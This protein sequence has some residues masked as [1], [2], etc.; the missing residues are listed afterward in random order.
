[1]KNKNGQL[2]CD[3][4]EEYEPKIKLQTEQDYIDNGVEFDED[5]PPENQYRK[6]EF[7]LK[8]YKRESAFCCP[9]HAPLEKVERSSKLMSFLLFLNMII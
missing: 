6:L 9:K 3:L 2:P 1:M 4:L 5:M 7:Y 8:N